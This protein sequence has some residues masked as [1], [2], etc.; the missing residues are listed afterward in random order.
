MFGAL[1]EPVVHA[2]YPDCRVEEVRHNFQKERR[3]CDTLEPVLNQHKLVID[4][5]TIEAD[6]RST[7]G[8]PG[9]TAHY[10][11]GLFQ[12]TRITRDK[13]AIVHDDRLDALA[14]GVA[15][16]VER[17]DVDVDKVMQARQEEL[18]YEQIEEDE[19]LSKGFRDSLSP[20]WM[21]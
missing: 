9:E 13:G 12:L 15:H 4:P 10:Y 8:R 5:K 1:L 20:R 11:Q 6:Y 2:F 18:F 14:I 19:R 21:V 16:F 7:E 3:I 17:M